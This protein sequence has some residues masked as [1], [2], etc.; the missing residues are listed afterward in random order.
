MNGGQ[1]E[2]VGAP[3]DVYEDPETRFVADFLGVA[4][5]LAVHC[6]GSQQGGLQPVRLGD[7]D[8][9]TTPVS[10]EVRA[11]DGHV[12]IR[13]E[14]VR[15][16]ARGEPAPNAVD[17]T[18][19]SLVYVGATTQVAVRL[20]NDQVLQ[21]L[22]VNDGG[23]DDLAVGRT[24]DRGTAA[25]CPAAAG[26]GLSL[27]PLSLPAR[28]ACRHHHVA[29]VAARA[30]RAEP[31]SPTPATAASPRHSAPEWVTCAPRCRA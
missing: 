17:G 18:V 4:N 30:R 20:A 24:G 10:D 13:P 31:R 6:E 14:R 2:Q 15:L 22:V 8:L 23:S 12:V 5:M 27:R 19:Q 16:A 1:I 26:R 25:R 11:G 3:Q 21:A 29:Y 7:T 28:R 9:L